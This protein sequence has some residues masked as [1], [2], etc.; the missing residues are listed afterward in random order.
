ML[1]AYLRQI[2]LIL[3]AFLPLNFAHSAS[4]TLA[5]DANPE[6]NI[7]GYRVYYSTVSGSYGTMIQV[8][9]SLSAKIDNLQPGTTY[10][11]A[12]TAYDTADLESHPSN[13][14]SHTL[15][16]DPLFDNDQDGLPD[17]WE[18]MHGLSTSVDGSY[19]DGRD[20]DPDGDGISNFLEYVLDSDP[21]AAEPA[22]LRSPQ[23]MRDETTGKRYLTISVRHRTNDPRIVYQIQRSSNL[24]IWTNAQAEVIAPPVPNSGG[25]SE[26]LTYRILPSI[27]EDGAAFVRV[28][29]QLNPVN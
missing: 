14:L 27:D 13:E 29:T 17:Q 11:F 26:T 25:E 22:Q 2:F 23:L 6:A 1:R 20:G 21:Q 19:N 5:W 10:Y 28:A 16:S 15:P 8:G 9:N 12:V 3:F 18:S 4:V 7:V 24:T